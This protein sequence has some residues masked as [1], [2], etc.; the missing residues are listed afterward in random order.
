MTADKFS[1]NQHF[2][3]A[4]EEIPLSL[5]LGKTEGLSPSG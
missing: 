5:F 3:K 2:P 1:T 4:G